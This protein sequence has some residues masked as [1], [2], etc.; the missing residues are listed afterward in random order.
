MT[1]NNKN[2][3]HWLTPILHQAKEFYFLFR[4]VVYFVV[5]IIFETGP[6]YVV[7]A[8][9]NSLCRAGWLELTLTPS[10]SPPGLAVKSFKY[11]N[12]YLHPNLQEEDGC[13]KKPLDVK[14][15]F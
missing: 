3:K 4:L 14:A 7:L 6:L 2:A 11:V 12:L 15:M 10:A 8:T 9:W 5:A 13:V 1:I